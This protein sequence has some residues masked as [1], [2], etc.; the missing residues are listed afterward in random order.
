MDLTPPLPPVPCVKGFWLAKR[1][2]QAKI[3]AMFSTLSK[4]CNRLMPNR[5][6]QPL[7]ILAAV[8]TLPSMPLAAQSHS[9]SFGF[10]KMTIAANRLALISNPVE[11]EPDNHL[12]T[13]LPLP[14][15]AIGTTLWRF[16]AAAQAY[17]HPIQWVGSAYG[18]LSV[19]TQPNWLVLNPG[20]AVIVETLTDVTL[21][22]F[23]KVRQ[24]TLSNPAPSPGF[25]LQ[26]SPA[27][28]SGP[29]GHALD[30]TGAG[31]GLLFPAKDM[32]VL[33]I[34]DTD[35][36]MF[37]TTSVYTEGSGWSS[38]GPNGPNIPL[39]SAFF[40]NRQFSGFQPAWIRNFDVNSATLQ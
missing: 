27:A 22:F 29:I 34:F 33:W 16:D 39:A 32:D 9:E 35:S 13:I 20:E 25:S 1:A 37:V 3:L 36:Q 19:E 23:G 14:E 21:T 8:A 2:R 4:M 28:Q 6:P 24:G 5:L 12:N 18:W 11:G 17:G 26:A 31:T 38:P 15:T 40:V 7:F 10:V 30:G